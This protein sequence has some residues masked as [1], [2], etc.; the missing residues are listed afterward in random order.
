MG[1]HAV[2]HMFRLESSCVGSIFTPAQAFKRAH[3]LV[4]NF[5]ILFLP[6]PTLSNPTL[7]LPYNLHE[8]E[9][10]NEIL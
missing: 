3:V 1:G 6:C 7:L 10:D 9:V 2:V 5:K 4:N 8:Y